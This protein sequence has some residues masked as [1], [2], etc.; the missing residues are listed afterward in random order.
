[1]NKLYLLVI[2]TP[3]ELAAI[4]EAVL[5]RA[6]GLYDS[7]RIEGAVYL[8]AL[9]DRLLWAQDHPYIENPDRPSGMTE[10]DPGIP[11]LLVPAN[12]SPDGRM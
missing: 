6:A 1:M 7:G 10:C 8:N 12:S 3:A 11:I 2:V 9:D 5:T 4:R